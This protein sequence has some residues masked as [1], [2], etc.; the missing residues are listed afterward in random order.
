MTFSISRFIIQTETFLRPD[1]KN[2]TFGF[3]IFVFEAPGKNYEIV[4]RAG[5][6][7]ITEVLWELNRVEPRTVGILV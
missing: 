4:T 3:K 2:Q 1:L 7:Q 5:R 6:D